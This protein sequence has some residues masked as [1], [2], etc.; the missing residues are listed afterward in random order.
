MTTYLTEHSTCTS[1]LTTQC[2]TNINAVGQ[3]L[4]HLKMTMFI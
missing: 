2:Y 4:I 3:L 1:Q